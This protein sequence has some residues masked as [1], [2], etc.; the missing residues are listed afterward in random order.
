M[1]R[2]KR[3][4]TCWERTESRKCASHG[5]SQGCKTCMVVTCTTIADSGVS[6]RTLFCLCVLLRVESEGIRCRASSATEDKRDASTRIL[7]YRT[8][9]TLVVWLV[10]GANTWDKYMKS[11]K[12]MY[13]KHGRRMRKSRKSVTQ[14]KLKGETKSKHRAL[15]QANQSITGAEWF[16]ELT[17][18]GLRSYSV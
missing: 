15:E 18:T 6:V 1:R 11:M 16:A 17:T 9:T 8:C 10:C 14:I 2:M 7:A 12:R 13:L 3:T 5:L 4:K